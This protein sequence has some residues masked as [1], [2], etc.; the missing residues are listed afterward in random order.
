MKLKS[1][2]LICCLGLFSSAYAAAPHGHSET[3][4]SATVNKGLNYPGY[5]EIELNN[6]GNEP[7]TVWGNF[8]DGS[9]LQAFTLYAHST[10]YVTLVFRGYCQP[11]MAL[12]ISDVYGQIIY[13]SYGQDYYT[14]A[15]TIVDIYSPYMK[16]AKIE[17]KKK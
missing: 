4:S 3:D 12:K 15:D 5:C 11:K 17:V 10:D 1:L 7:V 16:K 9:P 13:P 6:Y 2:L 14:Y 8:I